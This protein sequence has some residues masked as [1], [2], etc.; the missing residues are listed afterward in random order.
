MISFGLIVVS[1]VFCFSFILVL[2]SSITIRVCFLFLLVVTRILSLTVYLVLFL[3]VPSAVFV[4]A[5][6]FVIPSTRLLLFGLLFYF[7]WVL[8]WALFHAIILGVLNIFSL[9]VGL[10]DCISLL[11]RFWY[12]CFDLGVD[13][14]CRFLHF[15]CV[16]L[17][18]LLRFF[19]LF[20]LLFLWLFLTSDGLF[21]LWTLDFNFLFFLL[22]LNF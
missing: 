1:S 4:S 22:L 7:F 8:I 6:V 18:C 13:C 14:R 2:I 19:N 10:V 5:I 16:F 11:L 3:V 15:A 12:W 17:F 20:P 21:N 9:R